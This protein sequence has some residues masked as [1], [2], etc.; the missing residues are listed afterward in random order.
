VAGK[1]T[2]LPLERPIVRRN[3]VIGKNIMP[4]R[5]VASESPTCGSAGCPEPDPLADHGVR[6]DESRER[7][8]PEPDEPPMSYMM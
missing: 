8:I 1:G 4:T 3:C 5:P 2:R 7:D 6:I